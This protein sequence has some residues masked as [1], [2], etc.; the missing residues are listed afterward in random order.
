MLSVVL[1]RPAG[2]PEQHNTQHFASVPDGVALALSAEP[3]ARTSHGAARAGPGVRSAA[4][5]GAW[6]VLL[7][8]EPTPTPSPAQGRERRR[9]TPLIDPR[10]VK[11][12]DASTRS[13]A[14]RS[15]A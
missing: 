2:R 12:S 9:H 3:P 14:V 4:S 11:H 5:L 1:L 10:C 15:S 8:G 13:A 6:L 7:P